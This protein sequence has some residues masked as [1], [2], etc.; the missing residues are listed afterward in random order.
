[1][2]KSEKK[3]PFPSFLDGL[4]HP[5]EFDRWLER[6]T[7]AHLRRDRNRGNKT[8]TRESYKIAIYDAVIRCAGKDVYTGKPMRWDLISKY[9][10]DA[11]KDGGRE[12]KKQFGD[13]PTVDHVGDKNE[14]M[15][16][17]ICAWRIN[18]AKND[19]TL[20]EFIQVCKEVL[21]RNKLYF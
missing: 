1:M 13:L 5:L 9:D 8:A 11:S 12:Y 16:F 19:L 7:L 3:Y 6:K 17:N 20:E 4:C 15:M 18:D 21:E 14:E 10:N 2:K